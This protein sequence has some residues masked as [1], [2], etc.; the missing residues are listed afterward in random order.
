VCYGYGRHSTVK[1]GLTRSAQRAKIK[2]YWRANLK[3]KGVRWGGFYYDKAVRGSTSFSEREQGRAVYAMAR[4]KD[5]VVTARL[6]RAFRS[7]S[8]GVSTIEAL[9]RRKVRFVSLDIR[10]NTS[11]PAGKFFFNILLSV[12]ELEREFARERAAE[13]ISFRRKHKLPL[14][15]HAPV[16]WK[17]VGKGVRESGTMK[18][19]RRFVVDADERELVEEIWKHRQRGMSHEGIALWCLHQKQFATKRKFDNIKAVQWAIAAR[20]L[21]YPVVTD[22]KKLVR[23]WNKIRRGEISRP[24]PK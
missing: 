2:E 20:E 21:Q 11:T 22:G 4:P 12:A 10:V 9:K 24:T 7:V 1:Q 18:S 3:K 19:T 5:Y 23:R 8:D 6:D 16:G 15:K 14:G 13:I 17:I